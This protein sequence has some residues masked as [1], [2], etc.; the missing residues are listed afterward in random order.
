[1]EVLRAELDALRARGVAASGP[2]RRAH[3][4]VISAYHRTPDKLTERVPGR[5]QGGTTG[6]GTGPG[7]AAP[8]NRGRTRPQR[9]FDEGRRRQ[10]VEGALGCKNRVVVRTYNRR[11]IGVGGGA[12]AL[13]SFR[14]ML[15]PMVCDAGLLLHEALEA[16]KNILF[17]A[18]QA[19]MLDIDHGTYPFVT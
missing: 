13:L 18:G 4:P 8:V 1:L 16:N 10:T 14:E 6:R 15:A 9:L 12:E 5:R 11:A 17:E 2:K 3:A 19:T 7:H